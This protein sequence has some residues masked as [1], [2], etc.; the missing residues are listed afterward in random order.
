MLPFLVTFTCNPDRLSS[1]RLGLTLIANNNK[2]RT[3]L[4][5]DMLIRIVYD[6]LMTGFKLQNQETVC[7][8][9]LARQYHAASASGAEIEAR[10]AEP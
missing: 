6:M 4:V 2:M 9:R 7:A 10:M 8:L 5:I 3:H 1:A